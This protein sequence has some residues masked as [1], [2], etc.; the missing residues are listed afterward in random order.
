M[1]ERSPLEFF[2]F[3]HPVTMSPSPDIHTVG[4]AAAGLPH[5][6]GR[7]DAE[8]VDRVVEKLRAETCGGGSVTIPHKESLLLHMDELSEAAKVIG[9]VNTVTKAAD[10]KLLGDN[11]DWLGIKQQLEARLSARADGQE[12]VRPVCLLCGAGGTARAAAFALQ[13]MGAARVLIFNRTPDRAETLAREFGFEALPDLLTLA[14]LEQ[15][16]IVVN[17]LPGSTGFELPDADVLARFR[18]VVF[19]AAYI[20][21]RTAFVQQALASGCEV[22][23][24]VEMLF[25]QGCAQCEIWTQRP[26][27]RSKIAAKLLKALFEAGSQHPAHEKMEPHDSPPLALLREASV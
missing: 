2:I 17:T 16:D 9:A 18:P 25:E 5:S 23:E 1:A 20:P 4:F 19:E 6:Y 13:R 26:A 7:F 11:T 15:L 14:N 3:G 12:R 8:D 22:V 27:P 21:R 24:G 10:G